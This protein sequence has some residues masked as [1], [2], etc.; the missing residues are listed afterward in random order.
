MRYFLLLICFFSLFSCKLKSNNS[1]ENEKTAA[2]VLA[3]NM[4]TTIKPAEDF[5][6]YANGGWIK[7]NAIPA[8][9]SSWGIGNLVIEENY[10]RLREISEKAAK[11]NAA[12][13]T[14]S[15]KIGD[16][17]ATAMDSTKIEQAGLKPLQ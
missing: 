2:D 8:E 3:V 10:K 17:W 12:K 7:N 4:D 16:F 13:G 6:L 1:V 11:E 15:Q 9:E 5:F 14:T